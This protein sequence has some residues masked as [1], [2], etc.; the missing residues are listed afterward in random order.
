MQPGVPPGNF[1]PEALRKQAEQM[2]Q[3]VLPDLQAAV[4]QAQ[5]LQQKLVEAQQEIA[6]TQVT[7]QAGGGLVEVDMI[8]SGVVT[9]VRIDPKVV[10]PGDVETLQDLIVGAVADAAHNM[11]EQVKSILG[12]LAAASGR[13]LPES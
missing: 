2:R 5:Q 7:G 10:D 4:A 9:A 8:G 3:Q 6:E 12:P 13:P 1:D 11:K